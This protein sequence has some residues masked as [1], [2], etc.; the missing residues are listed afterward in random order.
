MS[1]FFAV[2]IWGGVS[3]LP[4]LNSAVPVGTKGVGVYTNIKNLV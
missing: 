4:V 3:F 2:S 1:L